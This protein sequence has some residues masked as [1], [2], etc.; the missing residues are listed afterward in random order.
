MSLAGRGVLV[1]RPRELAQGLAQRVEAAGGRAIVFPAIEIE[2]VAPSGPVA[3]YDAVVFVSPTAV[4]QGS[5]WIGAGAKV[6]AVGAGTAHEIMKSREDV[7]FPASGADSEALLALPELAQVA[8]KRILIVRGAGG[9]SLLGDTL[10]ARGA[11]VEYAECYRR[12]RPQGDAAPVLAAQAA[13]GLHA[14]T[15]NSGEALQNLLALLGAGGWSRLRELP[16]FVPH[17]RVAAQASAALAREVVVAGAGDD[18]MIAR[19]VA[20]FSDDRE[21]N[22]P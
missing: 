20:Y 12:V 8:G 2:P 9:R 14:L 4:D 3:R 5:R 18:E 17:P 16:L 15:V 10:S 13:G 6:L 21:R 22:R 1:T 11:R 19:L 7:I